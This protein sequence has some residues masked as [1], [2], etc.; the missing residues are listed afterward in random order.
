MKMFLHENKKNNVDEN[1]G[2]WVCHMDSQLCLCD[3]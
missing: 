2:G 1:N 3:T